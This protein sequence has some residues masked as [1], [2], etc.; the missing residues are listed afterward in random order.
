[1]ADPEANIIFGTSFDDRLGDEIMITVIATGFD[2]SRKKDSS[3]R[4]AGQQVPAGTRN[5]RFEGA[6]FLAELERQRVGQSE[7]AGTH[8]R[9]QTYGPLGLPERQPVPV[10]VQAAPS[11]RPISDQQTPRR[12]YDDADLEI[13]SFLRRQQPEE[14]D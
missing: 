1:V 2:V 11:H 12:T 4:E 14:R 7:P 3:R 6:D 13:P 10:P 9:V 8:T 5:S